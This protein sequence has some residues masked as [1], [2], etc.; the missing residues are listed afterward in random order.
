MSRR[1]LLLIAAAL[2]GIAVLGLLLAFLLPGTLKLTVVPK[3]ADITIDDKIKTKPGSIRLNPGRHDVT[4]ARKGFVTKTIQVTI[5]SSQ[6]TAQ[7]EIMAVQDSTGV[8][9]IEGH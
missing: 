6:T 5:K 4:M 9:Y 2:G 8:A 1:T 3:D 7:V